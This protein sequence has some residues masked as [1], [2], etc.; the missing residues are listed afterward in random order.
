MAIAG[1]EKEILFSYTKAGIITQIEQAFDL[2]KESNKIKDIY[3][4]LFIKYPPH[5][6]EIRSLVED[7][8][9]VLALWKWSASA[10]SRYNLVNV[11]KNVDE[12]W[13]QVT[14][15]NTFKLFKDA[16]DGAVTRKAAI[17][18]IVDKDPFPNFDS[19]TSIGS[20]APHIK[21]TPEGVT[22]RS[23]FNSSTVQRLCALR[24]VTF[25]LQPNMERLASFF[26]KPVK[27]TLVGTAQD[28]IVG[29]V[30][31]LL[32]LLDAMESCTPLTKCS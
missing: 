19:L 1:S 29:Y 16:V 28:P 5:G 32:G 13:E 21:I 7:V 30:R 18:E 4:S 26:V 6:I 12:K 14:L 15:E 8:A 31:D 9:S 17:L 3:R 10:D 11:L 23:V 24:L 27:I 25:F 22:K 2:D 20:H